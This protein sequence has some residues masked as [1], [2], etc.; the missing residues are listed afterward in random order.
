[1]YVKYQARALLHGISMSGLHM[2]QQ[3]SGICSEGSNLIFMSYWL[4]GLNWDFH[5]ADNCQRTLL[6][7]FHHELPLLNSSQWKINLRDFLRRFCSETKQLRCIIEYPLNLLNMLNLN[8]CTSGLNGSQLQ[9]SSYFHFSESIHTLVIRL[10]MVPKV[11][12]MKLI[13]EIGNNNF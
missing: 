9:G 2:L 5:A 4:F 10:M 7:W 6:P 11:K 13:L 8:S 12:V 3:C 1:M